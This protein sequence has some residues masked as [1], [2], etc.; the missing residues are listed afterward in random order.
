VLLITVWPQEEKSDLACRYPDVM[1]TLF[2]LWTD[3]SRHRVV[4]RSARPV[5]VHPSTSIPGMHQSRSSQLIAP[6]PA[7]GLLAPRQHPRQPIIIVAITVITRL[8][9]WPGNIKDASLQAVVATARRLADPKPS[10]TDDLRPICQ[11]RLHS[12]RP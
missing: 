5:A 3:A 12:S 6:G 8:R 2:T 1:S 7:C 4:T 9:P 11:M 10:L